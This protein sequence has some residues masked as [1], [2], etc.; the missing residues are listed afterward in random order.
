MNIQWISLKAEKANI[1][2]IF[3]VIVAGWSAESAAHT[4]TDT[5]S[6]THTNTHMHTPIYAHSSVRQLGSS[7]MVDLDWVLGLKTCRRNHLHTKSE[8][9]IPTVRE[10]KEVR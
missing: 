6:H 10:T 1:F 8:I 5:H 3:A 7:E 9:S 4:D 2:S